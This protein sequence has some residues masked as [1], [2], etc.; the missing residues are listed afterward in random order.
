M[1]HKKLIIILEVRANLL[2]SITNIFQLEPSFLH[3]HDWQADP[4][5]ITAGCIYL[6]M[7]TRQSQIADFYPVRNSWYGLNCSA[8]F[9]RKRCSSLGCHAILFVIYEHTNV[10]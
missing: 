7:Q 8:K 4:N 9:G 3:D 1:S 2:A 10:P 6:L 5:F